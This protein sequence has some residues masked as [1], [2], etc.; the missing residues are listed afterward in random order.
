MWDMAKQA[1]AHECSKGPSPPFSAAAGSVVFPVGMLI[2]PDLGIGKDFAEEG[3]FFLG[4]QMEHF[5]L[6]FKEGA[7]LSSS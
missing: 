5:K 4:P 7:H 2:E 6:K 1:Y 3:F